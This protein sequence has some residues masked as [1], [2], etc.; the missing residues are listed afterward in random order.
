[1]T[2]E[3][4]HQRDA[5]IF[6]YFFNQPQGDCLRIGMYLVPNHIQLVY[7]LIIIYS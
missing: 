4:V 2:I 5:Y 7:I 1:M 3:L 6:V